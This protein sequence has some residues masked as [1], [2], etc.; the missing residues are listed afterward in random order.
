MNR[1]IGSL[2]FLV[3]LSAVAF[4]SPSSIDP[5]DQWPQFRGPLASGVGP[6]ATPP[7]K[8][9][10]SENIRWKIP[11][12]GKGLSTPIVWGDRVYLTTAVPVG[13]AVAEGAHPTREAHD[14]GAHDNMAP[15]HKMRFDVLAIDRHDGSIVW[16]KTLRTARPHEGT[17]VTGSWASNTAVTDGKQLY[18]SFG[19]RGLF[20]LDMKGNLVWQKDLGQMTTRHEHGEGSS[21][22]LHGNTL[23]VNWDHQGGSYLAAFDTRTG[24]QK[25]KV[26]RDEITSWS[27]PIIVEHR[28]RTQ[29]IVSATKRVRGY[30]LADG[31]LIWECGGLSRNVVASPVAANGIVYVANSYDWQ[32]LLAIRLDAA[33]GDITDS[34]AIVWKIDRLTPYVPS[35]VLYD[36]TI[37]F[38]RH[39]QGLLSCLDAK[40][41]V[42]QFGP[43]RLKTIRNVFASPVAAAQRIYIVDR[44]GTTMV[45]KHGAPFE[46]LAVN[47]LEDSFSASP[48]LAGRDLFLRG[49]KYLY[50]IAELSSPG[51]NQL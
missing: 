41:G 34:D 38:L 37:C 21:P 2:G 5:N 27:T 46:V 17:H 10:E 15:T 47:R 43:E 13:E 44:E 49:E 36:G 16:R 33:K 42:P 48:A 26:E 22:A 32:A 51:E 6:T 23:V 30:D 11:I 45:V 25:W 20:C 18:I 14:S 35:P 50:C 29:V 28:G 19:S 24:T 9:S 40:T 4:A 39:N 12:P 1:T 7:L 31:T 3:F 8:W